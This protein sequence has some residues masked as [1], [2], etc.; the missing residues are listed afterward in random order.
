MY[1]YTV[2]A[3]SI[4]AE[5]YSRVV[6]NVVFRVHFRYFKIIF[7]AFFF[8]FVKFIQFCIRICKKTRIYKKN[9]STLNDTAKNLKF[10]LLFFSPIGGSGGERF[11]A[12]KNAFS[13]TSRY[14]LTTSPVSYS[15]L[16]RKFFLLIIKVEKSH[17]Q[18]S[19]VGFYLIGPGIL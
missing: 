8:I 5:K 12:I 18:K 13:K 19:W 11:S 15:L 16:G 3:V 7:S 14:V 9:L 2:G 4:I 17:F 1:T 10:F 6:F